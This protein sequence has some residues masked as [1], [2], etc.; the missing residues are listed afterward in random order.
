MTLQECFIPGSGGG[1]VDG[2]TDKARQGCLCAP[3][4]SPSWCFHHVNSFLS[5]QLLSKARLPV[6]GI[7]PKLTVARGSQAVSIV[8]PRHF[9]SPCHNPNHFTGREMEI[10]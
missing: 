4:T 5:L 10:L 2:R 7:N 9:P 3:P 6:V 1:Q 8:G